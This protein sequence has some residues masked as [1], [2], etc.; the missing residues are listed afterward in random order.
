M[1]YYKFVF[2]QIVKHIPRYEFEKCV[3][4]YKGD[5]NAKNQTFTII[6]INYFFQANYCLAERYFYVQKSLKESISLEYSAVN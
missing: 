5:F 3:I 1:H 2:A 4:R 6:V